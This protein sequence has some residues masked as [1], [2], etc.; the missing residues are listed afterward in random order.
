MY[1]KTYINS[2]EIIEYLTYLNDSNKLKDIA[3]NYLNRY[4][5]GVDT[6]KLAFKDSLDHYVSEMISENPNFINSFQFRNYIKYIREI[7]LQKKYIIGMNVIYPELSTNIVFEYL[8]DEMLNR[9]FPK[10]S[11]RK[12]IE[13]N[14]RLFR[15]IFSKIENDQIL[16]FQELE[17]ISDYLD[18]K[19]NMSYFKDTEYTE[20]AKYISYLFNNK[21]KIKMTPKICSAILSFMPIFYRGDVENSRAYLG[22]TDGSE[23]INI[24]HSSG[25]HP[26]V[27]FE[28]NF[29]RNT[30]MN[31]FKSVEKSRTFKENDIMFL[32]FV[33]F[34]E[35]THQKRDGDVAK[36]NT[37]DGAMVEINRVLQAGKGR[38]DYIRNHDADEIEMDADENG[39]KYSACFAEKFLKDKTIARKCRENARAIN[40]R[41]AFSWKEDE[42]GK[43]HRY[44]DYDVEQVIKVIQE[45]PDILKRCKI[46]SKIMNDKGQIKTDFLS[47]KIITNTKPGREFCNYIFN[48]VPIKLLKEKINSGKYSM[49]QIHN[50]LENF[51]QVP[52]QNALIL[53]GL[54][55]VDLDTFSETKTGVKSK[56]GAIRYSFNYSFIECV[57]QLIKFNELLDTVSNKYPEE[58]NYSMIINHYYGFF[59]SYYVE[60]A[61][62]IDEPNI[63]SI[64][65]AVKKMEESNSER[66]QILAKQTYDFFRDEK[67]VDLKGDTNIIHLRTS[68][69]KKIPVN[70]SE[71]G[72]N[73]IQD[74]IDYTKS[75]I[76]NSNIKMLGQQLTQM[77][78]RENSDKNR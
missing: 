4:N 73:L 62:N 32:S 43:L 8:N 55:D 16:N 26:Y 20:Y 3:T 70:S 60:M 41:R 50:L 11:I 1:N 17:L 45:K 74:A 75:L 64:Y 53:R 24:A 44:I 36:S 40:M 23:R 7:N 72:N 67:G 76:Q 47:E 31:S 49:S 66:L 63:L 35:L 30:K 34:H 9:L 77:I 10:N 78:N 15:E 22:S 37:F 57:E 51:V 28:Y 65:K 52:H 71:K 46:L 25:R 56:K 27:C 21:D 38:I 13:K 61:R 39:W 59:I 5:K 12:E 69:T 54:K 48:R 29:F 18:N 33:A 14:K 42:N 68:Q 6:R 58:F 2:F 19:K